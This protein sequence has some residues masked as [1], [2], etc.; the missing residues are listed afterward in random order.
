[1]AAPPLIRRGAAAFQHAVT[2]ARRARLR[3]ARPSARLLPRGPAPRS[4]PAGRG[5]RPSSMTSTSLARRSSRDRLGGPL[6]ADVVQGDDPSGHEIAQAERQQ[7][8]LL[9]SSAPPQQTVDVE[10]LST[11]E[12]AGPGREHARR[13]QR[14]HDPLEWR[15]WVPSRGPEARA[16]GRAA[17]RWRSAFGG[18]GSR[19]ACNRAARPSPA[20]G[21][22]ILGDVSVVGERELR[23]DDVLEGA[24]VRHRGEPPH[25]VGALIVLARGLVGGAAPS[26]PDPA[27]DEPA[28]LALG[29][30]ELD[31]ARAW[32]PSAGGGARPV[33]P[34]RRR[35][36]SARRRCARERVSSA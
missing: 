15:A 27:R 11:K 36:R 6:G 32:R 23:G 24:R 8:A 21:E 31:A 4:R 10:G 17:P 19:L 18:P 33:P 5:L 20:D 9:A 26:T 13:R 2:A 1:M 22:Q 3:R 29:L 14:Q 25:G 30:S 28:Q 34:P 12:V 35:D 7:R 16:R